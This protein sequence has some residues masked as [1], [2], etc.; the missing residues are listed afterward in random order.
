MLEINLE[1]I[2]HQPRDIAWKFIVNELGPDFLKYFFKVEFKL[3]GRPKEAKFEVAAPIYRKGSVSS[4]GSRIP[5]AMFRGEEPGGGRKIFCFLEQQHANAPG[6]PKRLYTTLTRLLDQHPGAVINFVV[7]ATD[8]EKLHQVLPHA[9]N[10]GNYTITCEFKIFR[11][12]DINLDALKKERY[13]ISPFIHAACVEM[14]MKDKNYY[15]RHKIAVEALDLISTYNI[16]DDI[17]SIFINFVYIL[18]NLSVPILKGKLD[19]RF[20]MIADS[21]MS[22]IFRAA[23]RKEGWEEGLEKARLETATE[24]LRTGE[25]PLSKISQLCRL[26]EDRLRALAEEL[27]LNE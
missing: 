20:Q 8:G 17:V 14:E 26:P 21:A 12:C 3:L 27:N 4:K 25:F 10:Y 1:L 23:G 5:D 11:L 6:F 18:F 13:V 9:I 16:S 15:N 24:M 7:I 22:E 19:R 2:P